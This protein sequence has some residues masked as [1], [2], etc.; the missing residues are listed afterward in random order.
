M[1]TVSFGNL[2]EL[3][4]WDISTRCD[5]PSISA[6]A[7]HSI[8][9]FH[10]SIMRFL[11]FIGTLSLAYLATAD[12]V[13]DLGY[14][15]YRGN[16]SYPNTVAYLGLPYAEPPVGDRRWRSPLPLNTSRVSLEAHGAVVDAS[17]D[18]DFCI[19]GTTGS[20]LRRLPL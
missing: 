17:T 4:R 9:L 7:V 2:G 15:R 3:A 11:S 6:V 14:A 8:Q 20:Q 16:H 19:Q 13:V 12:T 18:P 10:S 1:P 5:T